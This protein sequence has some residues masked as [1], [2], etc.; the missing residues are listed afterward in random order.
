M[1]RSQVRCTNCGKL[2][3]K[4][5]REVARSER[6][7][8]RHFC[9]RSCAAAFRSIS[10][11]AKEVILICP[12]GKSFQTTAKTRAPRHCSRSCASR[13]GSGHGVR[14]SKRCSRCG[15]KKSFR[16]FPQRSETKDKRGSW[17]RACLRDHAN[18]KYDSRRAPGEQCVHCGASLKDYGGNGR[19]KFCDST[20][21]SRYHSTRAYYLKRKFGITEEFYD[22]LVKQ[23]KGVCAICHGPPNGGPRGRQEILFVDH[24]HESGRIRGL[25]CFRC[26]SAL[27]L[28]RDNLG[29][30]RRMVAYLETAGDP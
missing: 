21:K 6:R 8:S 22:S 2:F 18:S 30:A 27:G 13:F 12:C 15:Q 25:L 7:G 19:R 14:V 28:L 5:N 20:C 17:C 4:E 11:R 26:N 1:A 10:R 9:T 24:C 16:A 29:S 3:F 23:Q